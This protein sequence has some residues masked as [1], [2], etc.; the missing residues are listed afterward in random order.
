MNQT[1]RKLRRLAFSKITVLSLTALLVA[2][3]VVSVTNDLYA[4]VKSDREITLSI[5]EPHSLKHLSKAMEEQGVIANPTVFC[6]YVQAKDQSDLL[7]DFCG[8]LTLNSSMSYRQ[9][10]ACFSQ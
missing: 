10:V 4:F 1:R 3:I 5:D 9:I 6:L 8:T 2:A 7:E